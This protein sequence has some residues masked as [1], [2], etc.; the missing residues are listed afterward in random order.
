MSNRETTPKRPMGHGHSFAKPKNF[1]LALK[2]LLFY[3]KPF[4]PL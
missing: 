4:I 1:K 2:K 3:L